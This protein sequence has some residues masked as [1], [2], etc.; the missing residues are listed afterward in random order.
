MW[1]WVLN[2]PLLVLFRP[3]LRY[4]R[5]ALSMAISISFYTILLRNPMCKSSISVTFCSKCK[6]IVSRDKYV[7]TVCAWQTKIK[8]AQHSGSDEN[9][10][11]WKA[12]CKEKGTVT[13]GPS[14]RL[15]GCGYC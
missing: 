10:E 14:I 4:K 13:S 1:R 12:M 15:Y 9:V 3:T 8:R 5:R 7:D 6:T 2:V 11:E